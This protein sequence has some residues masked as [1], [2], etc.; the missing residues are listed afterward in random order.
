MVKDALKNGMLGLAVA[1]ALGVPVEF[2]S[3]DTYTVTQMQGYG[4]HN[5]PIGT[6]SDD[7]SMALATLE[8]M[9]RL[10]RT[11]LDDIMRNFE[12]WLYDGKFT[13]WG[14][15]FDCGNTC[16]AAVHNYKRGKSVAECGM[17]GKMDNGNGSLMRILPV[18]VLDPEST[19]KV[20]ALTHAHRIS[21]VAC[22]IYTALVRH[23]MA[24]LDKLTAYSMTI[25]DFEEILKDPDLAAFHRLPDIMTLDRQEI[26][27][28]GYVVD[29]LE[30]ALWCFLRGASYSECVLTAV[31]LGSD[32]D[33]VGAI[34]GG[35]AGIYYGIGG[36]Q[37]IPQAWLAQLA[38]AEAIVDCCD[39][40][41]KAFPD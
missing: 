13:P 32:T 1:D 30:A 12:Q 27:S 24:G 11:D 3:R 20:S 28:S 7:T 15:V 18:S 8:S 39:Q 38:K 4:T 16:S 34:C 29:S 35:L 6:W 36:E 37:G 22:L 2:R 14:E 10:G 33:T 17:G 19:V 25:K 40:A 41:T 21:S 31:N 23:L 9:A 5:Q 26:K